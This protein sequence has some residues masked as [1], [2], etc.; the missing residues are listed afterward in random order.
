VT[1]VRTSPS[2]AVLISRH[3]GYR[4][5]AYR[6]PVGRWTIGRGHIG[7][8]ARAG[9]IISAEHEVALFESDVLEAERTIR[10]AL[11]HDLLQTLPP[12]A[13]DA[14]TSFVFNVGA[15]AFRNRD[16]SRTGLY[17][18]L[19]ERRWLDVAAEMRRW[20]YGRKNGTPVVLPGLRVRRD[21]EAALWLS[22]FE[23]T[24]ATEAGVI[25]APPPAERPITQTKTVAGAAISVAAGTAAVGEQV[26]EAAQQ[27]GAF[28]QPGTWLWL[29]VGLAVVVGAALTIYGRLKVRER[30][31]E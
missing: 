29:L 20:V 27:A 22:A 14:L 7:P 18:A 25:P 6:D 17:R 3:E 26:T 5:A 24:D 9:N 28:A 30:S 16:G 15:Q 12:A 1:A 2:G 13:W 21:S 19:I 4:L 11:P 8:D 31:G 10:H 23:A